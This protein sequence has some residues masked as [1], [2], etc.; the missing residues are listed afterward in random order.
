MSPPKCNPAAVRRQVLHAAN[1]M[2][3]S[4]SECVGKLIPVA[5]KG[6]VDARP[7]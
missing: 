6:R 7:S 2:P 4:K 1:A 3:I 5:Q